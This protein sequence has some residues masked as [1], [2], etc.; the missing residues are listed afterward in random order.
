MHWEGSHMLKI[1]SRGLGLSQNMTVSIKI[2]Q[3]AIYDGCVPGMP[4]FQIETALHFPICS[5][6][7]F[8]SILN[9]EQTVIW[10][11]VSLSTDFLAPCF[12]FCAGPL[13]TLAF[14]S[15]MQPSKWLEVEDLC[16]V[17][18]VILHGMHGGHTFGRHLHSASSGSIRGHECH[19]KFT[20]LALILASWVC[21]STR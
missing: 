10:S 14:L 1:D 2:C 8:L 9:K 20:E 7:C 17:S 12:L 18:E 5:C 21:F 4:Q 11:R 15:V 19:D 13:A 3:S 16:E 6:R